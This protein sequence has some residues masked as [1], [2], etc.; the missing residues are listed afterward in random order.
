MDLIELVTISVPKLVLKFSRVL[1]SVI[2]NSLSLK[3]LTFEP[4][5]GEIFFS[6]VKIQIRKL[7]SQ[8]FSQ[9]KKG[10]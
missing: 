4:T 10:L 8:N 1:S 9:E 6:N 7:T 2:S 3:T 5:N